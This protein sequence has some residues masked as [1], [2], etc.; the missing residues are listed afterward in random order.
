MEN[1]QVELILP[2]PYQSLRCEWEG[3]V[4][5]H[6]SQQA[7]QFPEHLAVVD[8][9]ISWSYAELEKRA[10]QL[11]NYLCRNGIQSQDIVAIYAH[12]SASL[13]WAI[14]GILKAGAAFV[15][16]DPAYPASRLIDCLSVAKPQGWL[17]IEVA[18][19]LPAPLE[20][21]LETLSF[22]C[23]LRLSPDSV[24]L[25]NYATN[26]PIVTVD[27]DNL[28][29][30][31]FT[32]G[33]TGRPKGIIGTH[34][35]ISHFVQWH[36]DTFSFT[37]KD[38]FSM[39]SGLAHD[40]LLRDI[41]TP[42]WLGATLCIPEKQ[43]IETPGKLA[44]WMQR[45]Q[46]SITH[47]TPSMGQLLANI[48]PTTQT[49][50]ISCLRY[51]FFA[52]E[53]LKKHD[54]EKIHKLAPSLTCVNFYGAT[55]TPQAMGYFIISNLT[56]KENIPLGKG[57]RDVQLLVLTPTL[58]LAEIGEI[59]EIYIRTP[60]LSQGYISDDGLTQQ[61][62]R[63]NP[64]TKV[65]ED[66][67]YKTGDLG[68][69][70]SDGNIECLGRSDY[71]IKIR[72]F[73]V[74]IG[75][76]EAVLARHPG[77]RET[78]VVAQEDN[79]GDK[80]LVAYVVPHQKQVL[81]KKELRDCIRE[82]LPEYMIP[83]AFVI[84]DTLPLTPNGKVDRASLA[85][86]DPKQESKET[87]VAPRNELELKLTQIWEKV[88]GIQPISIKDN[89]FDLG[90]HSLLAIRLLTEIEKVFGKNL[91]LSTFIEAQTIEQ[92]ASCLADKQ[93]SAPGK[94]LVIIQQGST[95]PPL[96]CVHAIWGN[97]LF[98]RQLVCYLEPEQPF[99]ALQAQGLDGRQ[100][101]RTSVM[102][103]AADY[104]KE[105]RTVQPEGPY[106][107]GGYSFGGLLAFEIARQLQTQ[108][109]DIALLALFD[110]AAPGYAQPKSDSDQTASLTS[111]GKVFF[112]LNKLLKLKIQD[113]VTY[114]WQRIEYHLTVGKLRIFY[115]TY[116]RYIRRSLLDLHLLDV[117]RANNQARESYLP[118]VYSGSL[119]L[120]RASKKDVGFDDDPQLGWGIL[121]A[122]GTEIHEV[123]SSHTDMMTEPQVQLLAEKLQLCLK[124]QNK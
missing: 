29:Y 6:F 68:R 94:S 26:D 37:A 46:V 18:G 4:H 40:P 7:R 82:Q 71:Q 69:Y 95:K 114:I 30:I 45:M 111:L 56:D 9:G 80:C 25:K 33:S 67:L 70:L 74:E 97:V 108:G 96:F 36:C 62:F 86:P 64:F 42:L 31:A 48:T 60:Y 52:G 20:D 107:V 110:T 103:M 106:F 79:F 28:A 84:L 14:L 89:F 65:A 51:A 123:P 10:N 66:R 78:V 5:T 3:A 88:L 119:T 55:E 120:F 102:E 50:N 35:P 81:M 122:G 83:S 1:Y 105:I 21:F 41:F 22:C 61:R 47:L 8:A 12:R 43:D 44:D 2:D 16:L 13:V 19:E 23:H 11:A 116:L 117:A 92:L 17:Q 75:E 15:I 39:L 38:R 98:Y 32:S 115:R 27:P 85:A 76:I 104:I 63:I 49:D 109:Q 53:V 124:R 34:R 118:Q 112:H 87:F 93:V 24:A 100:A 101:P 99:Y 58:Q 121:A 73:R 90:G 57:I 91:T 77:V 54:V 72:G 59:G 113:Q